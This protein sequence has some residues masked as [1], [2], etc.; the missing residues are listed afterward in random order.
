M[1]ESFHNSNADYFKTKVYE[2]T[3]MNPQE[4]IARK[5]KNKNK[6]NNENVIFLII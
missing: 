2:C 6:K 1:Q 5:L 4:Q 3:N